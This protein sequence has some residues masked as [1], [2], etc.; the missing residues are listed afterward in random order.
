LHRIPNT[1]TVSFVHRE[2]PD[3][4]W[5]KRFDPSTGAVTALVRM[6]KGNDEG[7][8]AWSPDGTLLMSAGMKILA[9]GPGDKDWREVYDVAR[10][11]LGAVSRMAV[12]PDGRALAIV[13]QEPRAAR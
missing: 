6:P 13:V 11:K 9:W 1:R 8:V 10:H 3:T 12:A 5:V 2:T 7:D 4:I